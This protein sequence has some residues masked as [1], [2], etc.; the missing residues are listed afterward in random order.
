MKIKLSD[1][2]A[3]VINLESDIVKRESSINSL[4]SAGITNIVVFNAHKRNPGR[5][6]LAMSF[7]KI[8]EKTINNDEPILICE[9]DVL[10][11][12]LFDYS[13]EIEIPDDADAL[14]LGISKHGYTAYINPYNNPKGMPYDNHRDRS[15]HPTK[16]VAKRISHDLYRIYNM[17]S[18]HA[19]LIINPDYKR[20][21]N[22]AIEI[23]ILNNG[24][25]DVVRASTMPYWKVY[26]L[27][28]PLFFQSGTHEKTTNIQLSMLNGSELTD[29]IEF[30]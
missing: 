10:I 13:K 14:Y 26:A 15:A 17:L 8:F 2:Q 21:L 29:K 20:F 18:A 4:N 9:D 27:D 3:Y 22:N 30:L 5:T 12:P 19:V 7:K 24:H 28:M 25:Q 16:I 11:N 1:L 6:G 23:A